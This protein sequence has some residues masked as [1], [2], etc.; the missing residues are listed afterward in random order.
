MTTV[1]TSHRVED[2]VWRIPG[3][4]ARLLVDLDSIEGNVAVIAANISPKT[5]I[6]AVVKAGGYG[7]GGPLV[8]KAAISGG[9]SW[10]GV[11]TVEEG[12]EIR[13]AG[14]EVPILILGPS[15][16]E[17][18]L[19]ARAYRL[20]ITVGSGD[21]WRSLRRLGSDDEYEQPLGVHL[22]VNTGMNRYGVDSNQAASVAG[23]I[24]HAGGFS[25][26]GVFTHFARADESD[27]PSVRQ[28]ARVFL[29]FLEE[30]SREGIDAGLVHAS[31]SAAILRFRE[32]DF[33][34]VRPGISIYGVRPGPGVE[35][36]AG[37]RPALKV[38]AVVQRLEKIGVGDFVGYGGTY[39]PE[40]PERVGLLSLGYADGYPR[41]LS[42]RGWVGRQGVR[43]P[44]AGRVS[45]DQMSISVPDGVNLEQGDVV[46][47]AGDGSEGEPTLEEIAE[48]AGTIPYEIMTGLGRRLPAFFL[49]EGDVVAHDHSN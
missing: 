41:S 36:L 5:R 30:L 45:M 1:H 38:S 15:M 11:A 44:I 35:L 19:V 22:E 8:A 43:L 32:L 24:A 33:D 49:R 6:M 39:S 31:N 12:I 42:N 9:A 28:Q 21:Q 16:P 20:Q 29:S 3:R 46:T 40:A 48:I 37:M 47:V 4:G 13:K 14:I 17:E 25:L 18:S 34:I 2:L 26:N 10:L 7:H 23:S 27:E